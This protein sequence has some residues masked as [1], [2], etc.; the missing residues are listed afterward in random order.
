MKREDREL[1][2]GAVAGEPGDRERAVLRERLSGDPE[3][4]AALARLRRVEAVLGESRA[5]AFAPG[6]ALRVQ[7]R[8]RGEAAGAAAPAPPLFPS[9]KRQFLRLAP[10]AAAA[11]LVL[12]IHNVVSADERRQSL[13]DAALGLPPVTLDAAYTFDATWYTAEPDEA[14]DE[15]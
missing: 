9:L 13:V 12:A 10:I 11:V 4:R 6:F 5:Q 7:Q 14:S 3:L 2:M 1:L 8:L 15:D